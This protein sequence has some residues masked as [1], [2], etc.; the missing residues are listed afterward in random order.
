LVILPNEKI[1]G[2]ILTQKE[3]L[4]FQARA[5]ILKAM[6]HPTR[7]WIIKQLETQELC[8]NEI[9]NRIDADFSTVSKHLSILKN[10]GIIASDKRGKQV[11]YHL[12][13]P[14]ILKFMDCVE[15]VLHDQFQKQSNL[16]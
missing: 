2:D 5:D 12:C 9:V 8:V 10:S 7:L 6:A 4:I 14:C 1:K 15:A 16:I 3:K 13:V 11:F